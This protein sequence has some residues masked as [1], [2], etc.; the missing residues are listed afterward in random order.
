MP[1]ENKNK[2]HILRS[3]GYDAEGSETKNNIKIRLFIEIIECKTREKGG[4]EPSQVSNKTETLKLILHITLVPGEGNLR[5]TFKQPGIKEIS[6]I[7]TNLRKNEF[8]TFS[9]Y[10]PATSRNFV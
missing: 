5:R 8:L 3:V 6:R 1:S 4:I 2:C 9:M 10:H 7:L